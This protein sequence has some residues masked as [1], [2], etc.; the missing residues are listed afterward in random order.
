MFVYY[1]M[2]VLFLFGI[3]AIALED[4]IKVNKAATAVGMCVILWFLFLA[5]AT[6]LYLLHKPDDLENYVKAFPGFS[7]LSQTAQ[8]YKYI[9]FTLIEA[10]GDVDTTLFFVLASMT[11]IDVIDRHGGF[12]LITNKIKTNRK[13]KLLWII[14]IISFFM[15]A[16]IDDLAAVIVM[17]AMARKLVPDAKERLIY[18]C[19]IIV[20]A[21]AGGSW[22]PI[23]DVTTLILWT[24]GN[25]TVM[26]QIYH[27]FLSGLV[28][29]LV[30]LTITTFMIPKDSTVDALPPTPE[31]IAINA[32]IDP[33]IR[34]AT[35]FIG[36][37]SLALVPVF[38]SIFEL[39]PFMGVLFG[40]VILWVITDRKYTTSDDK[41]LRDLRVS[42]T[43]SKVDV[44]TIF[45]FLGI[46]MS[47]QALKAAGQL[48]IM[49]DFLNTYIASGT[50]K[51]LIFGICS[52]FLD[53]VALVSAAMGMYPLQAAGEFMVNG[54]FWLFL[55]Y[56]AVTGGSI[57]IIGSAS[58]VA[59]MG[60]EKISF[61]YYLKKF[62]P[63]VL[64]SYFVGAGVFWLLFLS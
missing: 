39:P 22:S 33:K 34:K 14:C 6:Q 28:M 12:S 18:S 1:L 51:A 16:I 38:Q 20:S 21:N 62:T 29:M 52:S 64:L 13:R 31:E 35:L 60:L 17:V 46:L 5:D 58:G 26:S 32:K 2:P 36:M 25:I 55:A 4:V 41:E 48:S 9:S 44:S 59:V 8:A 24:G 47:V 7:S 40:L 19:M 50:L 57:L 3:L 30:P 54:D 11:I 56:C 10:L 27:V 61:G 43:F 45:F 15:A 49:S 53:N 23:G 37:A 63:M 42:K